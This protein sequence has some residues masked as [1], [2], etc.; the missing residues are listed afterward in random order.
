VPPGAAAKGATIEEMM[1]ERARRARQRTIWVASAVA[2]VVAIVVAVT[3]IVVN[4]NRRSAAPPTAPASASAFSSDDAASGGAVQTSD[5]PAGALESGGFLLGQDLVPG[6]PAPAAGE[7]VTVEIFSD[8][9]CPWCALLEQAHSDSLAAKVQAGEIRLVIHTLNNLVEWND[10]YSWRAMIAADTV[11]ALEP[12]KFWEFNMALWENQPAESEDSDA[13]TDA[14]ISDLAAGVGVSQATIDQFADSPT[15]DWARWSSDE[16]RKQVD[17]TPVM[18]LSFDGSEPQ[19][20]Q[21]WLL[22][23]T[24][25][26]GEQVYAPGDLDKAIANVRGGQA[27]DAE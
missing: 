4:Q 9:L 5:R 12:D 22:Q 26:D 13:L 15:Q 2:L 23:G 27:P 17:G 10:D 16:G 14:E 1:R 21:G 8:Y 11:A 7:A 18:R 24:N 19:A 6:G 25:E 3:L 20:W